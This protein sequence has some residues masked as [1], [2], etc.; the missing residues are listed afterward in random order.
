MPASFH[1]PPSWMNSPPPESPD[2]MSHSFEPPVL[3]NVQRSRS[4]MLP[5]ALTIA[6]TSFSPQRSTPSPVGSTHIHPFV[7]P[8]TTTGSPRGA[9]RPNTTTW[10]F[11]SLDDV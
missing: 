9:P 3:S 1:T 11:D 4:P 6:P 5:P 10:A 7:C 8:P 2:D